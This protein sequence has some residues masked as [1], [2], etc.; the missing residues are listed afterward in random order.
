M[1][2]YPHAEQRL[3]ADVPG[4]PKPVAMARHDG[5][6][7]H[8]MAGSLRGT[9]GF[10]ERGN[11]VG[12]RG[13]ESHFGV[14]GAADG[15]LDGH[16]VQWV[17][18]RHR[19]DANLDGNSRLLSIETADGGRL[20]PWSDAQL[21][22]IARILAWA[23][24]EHDI[25]LQLMPDSRSSR[26]GIGFHRLGIDPWRVSGGEHWSTSHGK[27]CPGSLRVAQV[28]DVLARARALAGKPGPVTVPP[29]AAPIVTRPIAPAAPAHPAW[30]PR[31]Y[32]SQPGVPVVD[33]R[34]RNSLRWTM[35]HVGARSNPA[36]VDALAA[37]MNRQGW[38]PVRLDGTGVWTPNHHAAVTHGQRDLGHTV[39]GVLTDGEFDWLARYSKT[40][41][42]KG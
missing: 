3:L 34:A 12:L 41:A 33:A 36:M 35:R 32:P 5:V 37:G 42:V 18:T 16:V 40:L 38:G 25:P 1:A 29:A 27:V 10:F 2:L 7:L 39:T 15:A 9:E 17:D 24:T 20:V 8:T 19:A 14:G 6:V 28:P 22:S 26:Q 11:G 23:H 4:S 30:T 13:T 31:T 21:E